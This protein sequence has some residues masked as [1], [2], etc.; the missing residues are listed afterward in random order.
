MLSFSIF[1]LEIIKT[2]YSIDFKLS[3][4]IIL[5]AFYPLENAKTPANM[6]PSYQ[7]LPRLILSFGIWSA[8]FSAP[9]I[10]YFIAISHI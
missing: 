4:Q 5:H 2:Y 8:E 9:D 6:S 1:D 10:I 7:V 3:K